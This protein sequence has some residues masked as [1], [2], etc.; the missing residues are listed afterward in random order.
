MFREHT[1]ELIQ[2]L[3]NNQFSI[4]SILKGVLNLLVYDVIA[5]QSLA[6]L[7]NIEIRYDFNSLFL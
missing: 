3:H 1:L 2:S 4:Y 5:R 7:V 6:Y